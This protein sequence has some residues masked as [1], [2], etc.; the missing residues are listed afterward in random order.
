MRVWE[1]QPKTAISVGDL[2]VVQS[3]DGKIHAHKVEEVKEVDGDTE[4]I[5]RKRG[6]IWFSLTRY[7]EGLSWIKEVRLITD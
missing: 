7:F 3:N 4:I 6:N 1:I 2:L 5:L